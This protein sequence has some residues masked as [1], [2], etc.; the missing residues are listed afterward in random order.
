MHY[1]EIGFFQKNPISS[2][3]LGRLYGIQRCYLAIMQEIYW[4]TGLSLHVCFI[5]RFP[6]LWGTTT[7]G[8]PHA[9]N[10][11][12]S[13]TSLETAVSSHSGC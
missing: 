7:G 12:L 4:T 8:D 3:C 10:G 13:L 2:L 11:L 5:Q 1:P 9:I 6:G